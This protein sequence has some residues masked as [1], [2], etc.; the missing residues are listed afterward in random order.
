MVI[1][2]FV[3]QLPYIVNGGLLCASPVHGGPMWPNNTNSTV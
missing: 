1:K 2:H 3:K